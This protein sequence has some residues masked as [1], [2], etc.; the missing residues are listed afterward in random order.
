VAD[1]KFISSYRTEILINNPESMFSK[2][3]KVEFK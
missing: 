3:L 2:L 1:E